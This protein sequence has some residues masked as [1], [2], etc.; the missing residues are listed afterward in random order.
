MPRSA[1][2]SPAPV[3][4]S[5]DEI[6]ADFPALGRVYHGHRVAYFDGPGGTQ[7]PSAVVESMADHLIH[8]NANTHWGFPTSAETDEALF[9][10]RQAV[11]EFLN[12]TA[13]EIAFGLNMTT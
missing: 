7:V 11:A 3:V 12:A 10:A 2:P 9:Y 8:H 1:N 4:A 6:R 5:T 13:A